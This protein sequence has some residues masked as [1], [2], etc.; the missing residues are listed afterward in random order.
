MARNRVGAISR[1]L[2]HEASRLADVGE[3]V[4]D[5]AERLREAGLPIDRATAHFSILDPRYVGITR[6]WT[7]DAGLRLWRAAHSDTAQDYR[8]SPLQYVRHTDE[9]LDVHL[10]RDSRDFPVFVSLRREG[11]VHYVMAPL[12]PSIDPSEKRSGAIT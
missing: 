7:P 12:A 10:D 4:R 9:W 6:I 3:I 8:D 5:L 11:Y 2:V 1:W